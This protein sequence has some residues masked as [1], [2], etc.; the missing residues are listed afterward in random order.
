MAKPRP[1][2]RPS[3]KRGK[4]HLR[5]LIANKSKVKQQRS[6]K[7]TEKVSF[8]GKLPK[9]LPLRRSAVVDAASGKGLIGVDEAGRGPWAGP[10]VAA[11]VSVE[12]GAKGLERGITD[13]K[14]L[15]ESQREWLYEQLTSNPK[16]RWSAAAVSSKRI[17]RVNILQ[18][19]F[20]GM[21]KAVA[22]IAS[23]AKVRRRVL[24]DGNG[25]PATLAAN[26]ECEAIIKGDRKRFVI[27]AASIVAKVTR[28]RLMA[29]LDK[30]YPVYKFKEHKGYGTAS[31]SKALQRHGVLGIHR[32]S[33]APIKKILAGGTLKR[34]TSKKNLLKKGK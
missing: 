28:D 9:S 17:D 11:A 1:P 23:D 8:R 21:T 30:K 14:L 27:A 20:E 22:G 15:N 18:A 3:Q 26:H 33:Y 2:R 5:P 10:V 31:H 13:S 6:S 25:I 24:I 19:T 32:Q 4:T 16:V 29:K 7:G 12:P 34:K